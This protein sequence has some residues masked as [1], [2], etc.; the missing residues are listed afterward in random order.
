MRVAADLR[1]LALVG[2]DAT[3]AVVFED[4]VTGVGSA[5]AAGC[6][7]VL[8]VCNNSE[9]EAEAA[10]A[11]EGLMNAGASGA[12]R[13]TTDAVEWLLR[14]NTAPKLTPKL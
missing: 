2:G 5:V 1:A 12:F 6:A 3:H 10:E 14:V 9:T 11:A 4:S 13:T 7:Q 8:A